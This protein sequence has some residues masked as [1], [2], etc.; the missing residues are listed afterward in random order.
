MFHTLNVLAQV[1]PDWLRTH[2]D[3]EWAKRYDHRMEDYRLPKSREERLKVANTIGADGWKLLD[4]L[5][6][7]SAPTWLQEVPLFRRFA[8][9]GSSNFIL[10]KLGDSSEQRKRWCQL[11]RG[12]IRPMI[13]MPLMPRNERLLGWATRSI[14]LSS[15]MSRLP[16]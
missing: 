8:G 6:Q 7:Q 13:W 9:F 14:S 2:A 5:S 4:M 12:T 11:A 15:A 10:L 1:V 3:P 16:T